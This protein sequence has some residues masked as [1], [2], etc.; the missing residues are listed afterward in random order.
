[1]RS[2]IVTARNSPYELLSLWARV[3]AMFVLVVVI[4]AYIWEE[5]HQCKTQSPVKRDTCQASDITSAL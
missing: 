1:M 2:I 4:N 3:L 5:T